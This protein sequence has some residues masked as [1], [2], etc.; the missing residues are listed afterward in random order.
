ME[1]KDVDNAILAQYM[2]EEGI[3]ETST[4]KLTKETIKKPVT[5][6]IMTFC[7]H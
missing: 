1:E 2:M 4:K 5:S 7:L 6:T 3:G